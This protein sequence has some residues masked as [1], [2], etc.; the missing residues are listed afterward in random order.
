MRSCPSSSPCEET[1]GRVCLRA[2]SS[3][4]LS[5]IRA[6]A[7]GQ[8]WGSGAPSSATLGVYDGTP[9]TLSVAQLIEPATRCGSGRRERQGGQHEHASQISAMEQQSDADNAAN[10]DRSP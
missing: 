3:D 2:G 10:D 9:V 4:G 5:H 6:P 7:R 8:R 1:Y